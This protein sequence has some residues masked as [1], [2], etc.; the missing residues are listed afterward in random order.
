MTGR[1]G[2]EQGGGGAFKL[3]SVSL[4]TQP[5]A[6]LCPL[7]GPVP[8]LSP[9]LSTPMT[10][11]MSPEPSGLALVCLLAIEHSDHGQQVTNGQCQGLSCQGVLGEMQGTLETA[12]LPTCGRSNDQSS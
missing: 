6:E 11:A 1:Q 9:F 7:P 8:G 10:V 12:L 5:K 2:P 4:Q 3:Q